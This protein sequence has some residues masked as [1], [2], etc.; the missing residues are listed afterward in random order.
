M[1]IREKWEKRLGESASFGAR[2]SLQ[3]KFPP[4]PGVARLWIN[5]STCPTDDL[6]RQVA[7]LREGEALFAGTTLV[8]FREREGDDAGE[9]RE[10]TAGYTRREYAGPFN[11][12]IYPYHL[13]G[14]NGDELA[15]DF[16]L[17][18]AGRQGAPLDPSTRVAG[19]FP[20]FAEKGARARACVINTDDGP[21]YLGPDAE[22]MEGALVRG[23][24]ALCDGTV[25]RMG[26]RAYGATTLGPYCKCGGEIDNVIFSRYSSKAHDGFIGHSVVGAWCNIGAGTTVSNLKNS[27]ADVKLWDYA[28]GRFLPTGLQFC[29]LIA[30]DHAKMGINMMI[31]T[32]TVVGV[33]ADLHGCGFPRNFVPSFAWVGAGVF[34]ERPLSSFMDTARAVMARRGKVFDE[35]DRRLMA[36]LHERPG[37]E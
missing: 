31:N 6:C 10:I 34:R 26:A 13:F 14:Y 18:T 25:L 2:P 35:T 36:Y 27:Y 12:I 28:S 23:P 22:M 32:G 9:S 1:T 15:R 33:A 5:G 3:E 4:L 11:R 8:A 7:C 29:G 21:V 20:V 19:R 24:V 17:L 16:A 30:G 37:G